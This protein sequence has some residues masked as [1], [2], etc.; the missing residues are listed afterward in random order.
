M[1]KYAKVTGGIHDPKQNWTI[2]YEEADPLGPLSIFIF[3][4]TSVTLSI[5]NFFQ[6]RSEKEQRQRIEG[7]TC[8][9]ILEIRSPH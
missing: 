2:C 3:E 5:V 9:S 4:G 6:A 8:G 7:E 1:M